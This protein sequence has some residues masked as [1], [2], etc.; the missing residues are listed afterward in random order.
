MSRVSWGKRGGL[1][2]L[3]D[4]CTKEAFGALSSSFFLKANWVWLYVSTPWREVCRRSIQ[5]QSN[6]VTV[7]CTLSALFVTN[8][9]FWRFRESVIY[10]QN[11]RRSR[12]GLVWFIEGLMSRLEV[13]KQT[14]C[15]VVRSARSFLW[16]RVLPESRNREHQTM[17]PRHSSALFGL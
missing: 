15:M 10:P 14:T 2:K 16:N 7:N 5:Q 11:W 6:N 13:Y 8:K 12:F 9:T 4:S 3:V 1:F 17:V